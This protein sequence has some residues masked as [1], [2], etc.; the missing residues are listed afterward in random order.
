[1]QNGNRPWQQ[2]GD[3][4]APGPRVTDCRV[5]EDPGVRWQ[6]TLCGVQQDLPG[7]AVDCTLVCPEEA[8]YG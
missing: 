3:W 6:V 7:L 8:C 1:M 4:R 2:C 5:T